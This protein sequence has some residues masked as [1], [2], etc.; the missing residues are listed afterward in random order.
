MHHQLYG[1]R[2]SYFDFHFSAITN[3]IMLEIQ[4]NRFHLQCY[5]GSDIYTVDITDQIDTFCESITNINLNDWNGINFDFPMELFPGFYWNLEIETDTISLLCK[6][7]HNFPPNWN[8]F[9]T[10]L[11][12]LGIKK[13]LDAETFSDTEI[14]P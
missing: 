9:K 10:I 5:H 12:T 14:H 4:N 8:D 11:H 7:L 2:F 13:R 6:G 3:F 1:F